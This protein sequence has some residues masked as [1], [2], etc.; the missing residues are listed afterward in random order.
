[1]LSPWW[2]SLSAA[3]AP[4]HPAGS[5][6][7]K[8]GH[9][10]CQRWCAWPF[11]HCHEHHSVFQ[12]PVARDQRLPPGAFAAAWRRPSNEK[13]SRAR[14]ASPGALVR[15]WPLQV[16]TVWCSGMPQRQG[17][18][19]DPYGLRSLLGQS[20]QNFM[21]HGTGLKVKA[22]CSSI[23]A[24]K[25]NPERRSRRKAAGATGWGVADCHIKA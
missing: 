13:P 19:R 5:P 4:Q 8:A 14:R 2:S 1:M 12:G 15:A 7:A 20:F 23:L 24:A 3:E 6:Q 11:C 9:A 22:T 25:V 18:G 21:V 16:L 10:A 17:L